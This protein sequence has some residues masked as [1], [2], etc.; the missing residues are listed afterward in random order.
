MKAR[1]NWPRIDLL[2]S[3][4]YTRED[5]TSPYMDLTEDKKTELRSPRSVGLEYYFGTK[6]SL[7]IWGSTLGYSYMQ[8]DWQPVVQTRH[9]TESTTNTMTLALFDKLEDISG[10]QEAELEYIR[11]QDEMN[12]KKQEINLEVKEMF[13]KYKKAV[14]LMNVSKTKIEFQTKQVEVLEIRQELGEAQYSDVVEEMIKLA[15]EEF[16]Y[17]QAMADYYISIASLNKAVG[18]EGYFEI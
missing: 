16:S 2:G 9:G 12:R 5:Y 10:V 13:F 14:L 11:S 4:G 17:I 6:V 8:E 15:E 3:Y 7:P 18:I 1:S